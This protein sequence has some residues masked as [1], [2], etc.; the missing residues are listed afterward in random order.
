M[1]IYPPFVLPLLFV[2]FYHPI[3]TAQQYEIAL[4]AL[5]TEFSETTTGGTVLIANNGNVLYQ[6]AVG[7]ADR[8]FL[9]EMEPGHIHRIG[10]PTKQ[11]TAA[12]ILRGK[13]S[14]K[15]NITKYIGD[16]PTLG[17]T[18]VQGRHTK[19]EPY[20]FGTDGFCSRRWVQV[21]QFR[22]Y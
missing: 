20:I 5:L 12:A 19:K 8:E 15:P 16:Y 10:S 17:H 9:V 22:L 18:N 7:M 2:T 21:Q 3:T 13:L 4:D 11:F 14:V 1:K 6:K